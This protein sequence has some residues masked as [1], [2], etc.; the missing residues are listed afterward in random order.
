MARPKL[1]YNSIKCIYKVLSY[2]IVSCD[3]CNTF[4]YCTAGLQ[5]Q[6]LLMPSM[7]LVVDTLYAGGECRTL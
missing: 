7:S 3:T 6:H 2:S 5:Q 1:D 4:P